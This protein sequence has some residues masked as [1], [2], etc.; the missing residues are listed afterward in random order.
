MSFDVLKGKTLKSVVV[1]D[2]KNE[3]RITTDDGEE[4]LMW[5]SQ[6]C[7]EHVQLTEIIGDLQDLVGTPI[8]EAEESTNEDDL[9]EDHDDA[10]QW[11][12]YKL[13]T[14]KGHLTLRWLGE[15]N[16][17][18]SIDVSFKKMSDIES[19]ER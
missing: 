16:G 10:C 15:S 11:T 4:Y 6:D 3:V 9:P 17:Y 7:C 12:F 13:G 1:N 5:H 8:L 2:D 14:I 18:Y 19:W